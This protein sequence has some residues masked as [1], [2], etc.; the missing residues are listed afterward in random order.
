MRDRR[1]PRILVVDD[2]IILGSFLATLLRDEGY[3]VSL[4][5]HGQDALDQLDQT[6]PQLVLTDLQMPVLDGWALCAQLRV[7]APALPVVFMSAGVDP[8]QEAERCGAAGWLTKP[9]DLDDLLALLQ[10]LVTTPPA[11]S[12]LA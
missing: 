6:V 1:P 11:G 3:S 8:R 9:F 5:S 12:T 7:R 4:A 10:R 2:D